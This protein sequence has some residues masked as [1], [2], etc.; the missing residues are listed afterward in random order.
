MPVTVSLPFFE[1]I[2]IIRQ[3]ARR[4]AFTLIELLVVI[5]IIAI[6]IG[7]L[8]PAVQKVREAA[9]RMQ[10]SNNMK[11]LGLGMHNIESASGSFPPGYTTYS[12]TFNLP[13]NTQ[14]ADGTP[15]TR[16]GT[17][18]PYP[19]WVITGSQGG[20]LGTSGEVYGPS[21]VMHIY[22]YMEQT[23]LDARIN[24]GIQSDDINEACPWDN[25]DG[26]PQRRPDIDT[27][28]F[29]RKA[30]SCPSATQ[31]DVHFA[32]FSVENLL[33]ANY[34]A[35]FGGG[36]GRDTRPGS[37]LAGVFGPVTNV[38]K[39]PFG[40]RFGVGKGTK[41]TAITDGTSNTVMLSEVLANHVVDPASTS[42]SAPSGRN[43]DVRGAILCP[44]IGGNS[45]TGAFP[46][47]SRN[48]DVM[49]GCPPTGN[50]AAPPPTDQNGM[51]CAQNIDLNPT[52]GGQ[53]QVAARSRHTGGAMA[54]FADGS[55]KFIRSSVSQV[56]WS[57]A[58]TAQGGEVFNLD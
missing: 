43:A 19:A 51:A 14:N 6:L 1:R 46:P 52:T 53:W 31:S 33:K 39:H 2:C 11:Q 10:C 48:T 18:V 9:A 49:M 47:N 4:G 27:Q 15:R 54:C 21:W 7:L 36:F 40:E 24:Q 12:E 22:S 57:A 41:I 29:I 30:M 42:S 8:L 23:A 3:S 56:A 28:T 58:N 16:A 34:V 44:M 25:L 37:L 45:F 50:A 38:R 20:G 5:A 35:S 55:V 32:S 13:I 26:L 17:G